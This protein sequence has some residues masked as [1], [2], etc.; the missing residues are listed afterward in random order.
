MKNEKL[1]KIIKKHKGFIRERNLEELKTLNDSSKDIIS[2]LPNFYKVNFPSKDSIIKRLIR[3]Y[4]KGNLALVLGSGISLEHGLPTWNELILENLI[5]ALSQDNINTKAIRDFSKLYINCFLRNPLIAARHIECLINKNY[6]IKDFHKILKKT[7]YSREAFKKESNFYSAIANLCA[8][9]RSN[10][11]ISSIITY[12][13]DNLLEK[14][15]DRLIIRIPYKV[16][17]TNS[18]I[19]D[20]SVLAIYHVHGFLPDNEEV[21]K[22]R[23]IILNEKSYH[24]LYNVPFYWS[25]V[26]QLETFNNNICLFIGLSMNDPDLRRLLDASVKSS[27]RNKKDYHIVILKIPDLVY[28]EERYLKYGSNLSSRS[29]DGLKKSFISY[30]DNLKSLYMKAKRIEMH[31]LNCD[32]LFIKSF[33]E[34]PIILEKIYK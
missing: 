8:S 12:N 32:I 24:N 31:T 9:S 16:Y 22:S 10:K 20:K 6:E 25:N 26:V 23:D 27:K 28:L 19:K 18:A 21:S 33:N 2:K 29:L 30:S 11:L 1:E 17:E 4:T 13:F 34:I 7:L 14:Y 3:A 15:I 5:C